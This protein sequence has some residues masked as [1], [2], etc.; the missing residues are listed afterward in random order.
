MITYLSKLFIKNHQDYDDPQV[1]ARYGMLCGSAGI[2]FNT[3]L[4]FIK[5]IAGLLS[6]S[7]A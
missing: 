6:H 4:F 3:F 1:R 2:C 7:I 5:F